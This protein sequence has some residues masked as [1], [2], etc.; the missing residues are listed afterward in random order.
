MT[1]EEPRTPHDDEEFPFD[2]VTSEAAEVPDVPDSPAD[3]VID[4]P[5]RE[6]PRVVAETPVG[7]LRPTRWPSS[8][9]VTPPFV[10]EEAPPASEPEPIAEGV[11]EAPR[12]EEPSLAEVEQTS[13]GAEVPEPERE[14]DREALAEPEPESE[15]GEEVAGAGTE[16]QP[17]TA[18]VALH[19]GDEAE[20][21]AQIA[22][23]AE[24]E[25]EAEIADEEPV[26][27]GAVPDL[28][29]PAS[30][31]R[32]ALSA[33]ETETEQ[34]EGAPALPTELEEGLAGEGEWDDDLSPAL[35]A[36]LFGSPRK[37]SAAQATAEAAPIAQETVAAALAEKP[38]AEPAGPIRLTDEAAAQTLPITAG[39]HTVSA[40][41][42]PLTGKARYTRL[43][44]PLKG[45]RGLRIVETWTYFK[46]DYPGL[47]GQLVRSVRREEERFSD[48]SWRW[49]YERQYT[50]RG[51]DRRE[52]SANADRTYFERVDELAQRD[53]LT[54]KRQQ[55]K[56]E[57]G[58]IF[59]PPPREEKRGLFSSLL[60]RGDDEET[61]PAAWR[62]ATPGD[63]RQARKEGGAAFKRGLF[64]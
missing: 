9:D 14:T 10:E 7:G 32:T 6:P 13:A 58:M 25:G 12:A 28:T 5:A 63:M 11:P 44:E 55:I 30:I 22:V 61:G 18:T 2:D 27:E 31:V 4:L 29:A 56:E 3:T 19:A 16:S 1:P 41:D 45:D 40:P 15:P 21:T 42:T 53:P 36:V 50:D 43:E 17:E 39:E 64:G 37:P 51:R 46:P 26:L 57:A 20:L 8:T 23:E 47:E 62:E 34:A 52:V 38:R 48:G 35:A 59:A 49:R 33:M 24:P 60:R 54:G